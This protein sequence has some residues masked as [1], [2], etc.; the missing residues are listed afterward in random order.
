MI[1]TCGALFS[2]ACLLLLCSASRLMMKPR[3]FFLSFL[4][5]SGLELQSLLSTDNYWEGDCT[6]IAYCLVI[7]F[8]TSLRSSHSNIFSFLVLSRLMQVV[9]SE[10]LSFRLLH[11]PRVSERRHMLA[12]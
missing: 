8:A 12:Y 11:F 7:V 4:L 2:F 1:G 9:L 5:S 3:L 10:C 6:C